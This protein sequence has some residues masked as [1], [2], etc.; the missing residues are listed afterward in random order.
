MSRRSRRLFALSAFAAAAATG[1]LVGA[2]PATADPEPPPA[3]A[4]APGPPGLTPEQQC[5]WIAYRMWVPC[6]W[7]MN[8]PPPPGTPGSL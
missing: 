3:P 1:A 2:G 8:Q 4:P 7:V 5:A 6:N